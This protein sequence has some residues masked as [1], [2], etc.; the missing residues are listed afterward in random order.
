MKVRSSPE[1]KEPSLC[2]GYLGHDVCLPKMPSGFH[3]SDNALIIGVRLLA[4]RCDFLSK[5]AGIVRIS[6]NL[7]VIRS[8]LNTS[9][10]ALRRIGIVFCDR[11]ILTPDWAAFLSLWKSRAPNNCDCD[12]PGIGMPGRSFP[13]GQKWG[14]AATGHAPFRSFQA[15]SPISRTP[16]GH[17]LVPESRMVLGF[18]VTVIDGASGTPSPASLAL[19]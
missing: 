18:P 3:G 4:N 1:G 19:T 8:L 7:G 2:P 6:G 9:Q 12:V 17:R 16:L 13:E 15:T 14:M 10:W 11:N 5:W